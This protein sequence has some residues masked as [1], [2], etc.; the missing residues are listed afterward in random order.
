[1]EKKIYY[2]EWRFAYATLKWLE[3]IKILT[4]IEV[5]EIDRL[6]RVGFN[7]DTETIKRY[8]YRLGSRNY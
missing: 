8:I 6:N 7:I 4:P 2:W 1:M 3:S 5:K